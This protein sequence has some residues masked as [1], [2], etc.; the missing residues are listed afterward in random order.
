MNEPIRR[1]S[2]LAAMLFTALLVASTWLQVI[3]AE[4]INERPD[5]RRTALKN[6]AQERGQ[7]LIDGQ[8][9]ARSEPSDDELRWQR[10]Y[11]RTLNLGFC[12]ALWTRAFLAI[13][14]P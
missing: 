8:P 3:G 2:M 4:S 11:A 1:L 9:I 7:I 14:S 5:N 6:Y 12:A 13:S 10:V